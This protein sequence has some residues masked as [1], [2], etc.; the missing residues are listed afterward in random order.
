[1]HRLMFLAHLEKLMKYFIFIVAIDAIMAT[2]RK[3]V[4]FFF[5][6]GCVVPYINHCVYIWTVW[7]FLLLLLFILF[8]TR[9]NHDIDVIFIAACMWFQVQWLNS[10]CW[11]GYFKPKTI[12][13][14]SLSLSLLS[15]C[16]WHDN[17]GFVLLQLACLPSSSPLLPPP[18]VCSMW[19]RHFLLLLGRFWILLLG[20]GGTCNKKKGGSAPT[21]TPYIFKWDA[22]LVY[23]Y[24]CGH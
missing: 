10:P 14:Q 23:I 9:I 4:K 19:M 16:A 15:L 20:Q 24:S 11:K 8:F 12:N 13:H 18:E 7:S 17:V 21:P 3:K 6:L 5:R 2:A 1:M 22:L